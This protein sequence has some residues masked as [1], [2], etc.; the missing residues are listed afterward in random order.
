MHVG[1]QRESE[2]ALGA[3]RKDNKGSLCVQQRGMLKD[4]Q[5][6]DSTP[7]ARVCISFVRGQYITTK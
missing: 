7:C 2:R 6:W 3:V 5:L 1:R 4:D